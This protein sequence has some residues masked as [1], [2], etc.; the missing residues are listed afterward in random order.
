MANTQVSAPQEE[1]GSKHL[2]TLTAMRLAS[3][4]QGDITHLVLV[5]LVG[6]SGTGSA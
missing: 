6:L 3:L 2:V 1:D 5:D 4:G